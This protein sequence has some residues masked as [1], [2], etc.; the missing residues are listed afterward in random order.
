MSRAPRRAARLLEHPTVHAV[1]AAAEQLAERLRGIP[2]F[3]RI[4]YGLST[5]GDHG[6]LWHIIGVLRAVAGIDTPRQAAEL[7]GGLGIEAAI[8]NGPVKEIFR[9][10]RPVADYERPLQLRTPRTSSFPSGHASAGMFAAVLLADRDRRR[11]PW[12]LLGAAMGWSRVHV[13]I[14]HGSDVVGGAIVGLVLGRLGVR[15]TRALHD[16]RQA[17]IP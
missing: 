8:V 1:D 7:S 10:E 5:Y 12:Y 17:T 9:R 15:V 14:H 4:F 16:R 13:R 2:V 6:I 3:D 11:W